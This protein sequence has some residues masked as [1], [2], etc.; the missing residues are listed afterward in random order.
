MVTAPVHKG[1]INESG[2]TFTGHT[3]YLAEKSHADQVVVMLAG[4][5]F[6]VTLATT[7][8]PLRAVAD[9]I[10]KPLLK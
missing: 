10:T 2:L 6:R 1:I 8:L 4:G 9:T 7:H 3:E 5:G